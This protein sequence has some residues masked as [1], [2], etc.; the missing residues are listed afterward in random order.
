MSGGVYFGSGDG[1]PISAL[2]PFGWGLSYTS[3]N[4][5]AAT[6]SVL[7]RPL[8]HG[9]SLENTTFNVSINVKNVGTVSG[10]TPIM[11]TYHK[12]QR[13]VVRNLRDLCGF[14]KVHLKPGEIKTVTIQIRLSDLARWDTTV[15]HK[16]MLNNSV[17]GAY[18]VDQGPYDICVGGCV[19]MGGV[20]DDSDT[21]PPS[22]QIE[23][24]SAITLAAPPPGLATSPEETPFSPPSPWIY[25]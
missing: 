21:C 11:V 13:M 16:D 23:V 9:R 2:W 19:S 5:S 3:Y 18:V 1:R 6:V 24:K 4:F 15:E 12:T 22:Q 7:S 17:H 20:W 8:A 25:L 14:S 10:A